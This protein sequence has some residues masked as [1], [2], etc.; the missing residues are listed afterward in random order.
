MASCGDA[1]LLDPPT[2][3]EFDHHEWDW[4]VDEPPPVDPAPGA[5]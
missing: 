2:P 4:P 3:T 1:V 5:A